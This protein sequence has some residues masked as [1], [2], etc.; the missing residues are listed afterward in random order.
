M[1]VIDERVITSLRRKGDD[2][3]GIPF[4]LGAAARNVTGIRGTSVNNIEEQFLIGYDCI[5]KTE[6]Q[7]NGIEIITQE[8]RKPTETKNYYIIETTYYPQFQFLNHYV[9]DN[10]MYI[11]NDY[12]DNEFITE[13]NNETFVGKKSNLYNIVSNTAL[14]IDNEKIDESMVSKTILRYKGEE[15]I[16]DIAEKIVYTAT[17]IDGI[18]YQTQEI[19]NLLSDEEVKGE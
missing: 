13:N 12:E 6:M 18:K 9:S 5:T 3:M 2:G 4:P 17:Y 11:P 15:E 7:S 19:R 16:I 8:C 14:R 10:S 1:S